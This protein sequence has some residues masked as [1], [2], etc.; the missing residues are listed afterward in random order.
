M[1]AFA[2]CRKEGKEIFKTVKLVFRGFIYQ[3][4]RRAKK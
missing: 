1:R 2:H 4:V 3:Q